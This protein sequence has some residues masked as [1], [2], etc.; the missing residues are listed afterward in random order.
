MHVEDEIERSRRTPPAPYIEPRN[1]TEYNA[2]SA[3]YKAAVMLRGRVEQLAEVAVDHESVADP[4]L[5]WF[6]IGFG[7]SAEGFNGEWGPSNASLVEIFT[8]VR[9]GLTC[10]ERRIVRARA[11][12]SIDDALGLIIEHLREAHAYGVDLPTELDVLAEELARYAR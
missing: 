8:K 7:Y 9:D 2:T 4:R 11:A 6:L 1:Q 3:E 10:L 12:R 5:R